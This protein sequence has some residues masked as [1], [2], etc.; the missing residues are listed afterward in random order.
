MLECQRRR[1]KIAQSQSQASMYGAF[2]D[3]SDNGRDNDGQW[4]HNLEKRWMGRISSRLM[5]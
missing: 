4:I 5:I 3:V 1:R 2:G